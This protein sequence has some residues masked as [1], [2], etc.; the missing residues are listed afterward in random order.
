MVLSYFK[1]FTWVAK[2]KKRTHLPLLEFSTE[3]LMPLWQ[4]HVS[5]SYL[6][7]CSALKAVI[8][9]GPASDADV[10]VKKKKEKKISL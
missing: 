6:Y 3:G 10:T 5:D 7:L 8:S 9:L 2:R 4:H 1:N